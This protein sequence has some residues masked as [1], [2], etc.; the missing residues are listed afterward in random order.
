LEVDAIRIA[1]PDVLTTGR[2]TLR[3]WIDPDRASF[4]RMNA[5]PRVMEF[6][7]GCLDVPESDRL[8]DRI[9]RHFAVHGFGLYAV[10]LRANH[11]FAGYIGLSVPAF[12]APFMPAIEIGWRLAFEYWGK[13]LAT[14]GAREVIRHAFETLGLK[15]LVSFTAPSNLRSIRVM[16]KLGMTHQAIDDFEH[17]TLNPGHRLRPHVLYRLARTQRIENLRAYS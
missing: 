16:E 14:E 2:L 8:V 15:D 12:D 11:T 6:M 7:P 3:R 1:T 10:E 13:G 5:D 17:P 9:D 4:A